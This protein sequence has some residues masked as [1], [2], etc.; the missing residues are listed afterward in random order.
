M[1]IRT[2]SRNG[3]HRRDHVHTEPVPAAALAAP[4]D[5]TTPTTETEDASKRELRVVGAS[6]PRSDPKKTNIDALD[7]PSLPTCDDLPPENAP[8]RVY[9]EALRK[10]Q[11]V[12]TL[13]D[14]KLGWLAWWRGKVLLTAERSTHVQSFREVYE[15]LQIAKSSAYF[16]RAVATRYPNAEDV[17]GRAQTELRNQFATHIDA[18]DVDDDDFEATAN[19][20]GRHGAGRTIKGRTRSAHVTLTADNL[21]NRLDGVLS[22]VAQVKRMPKATAQC[23]DPGGNYQRARGIVEKIK[24]ACDEALTELDRRIKKLSGS[25]E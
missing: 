17:Q 18:P 6:S 22:L 19:G 1:P 21:V 2:N 15:T 12:G 16:W 5:G 10:F 23:Q 20:K 11:P 8:L 25:P 14:V 3:T 7:D 9:Q 13:L 4:Q 24:E